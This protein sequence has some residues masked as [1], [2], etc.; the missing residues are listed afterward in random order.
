MKTCELATAVLLLMT[1]G[2]NLY[3]QPNRWPTIQSVREKKSIR[4]LAESDTPINMWIKGK[5]GARLY[6]LEC[7]TGNYD[8]ESEMNFSGDYQCALF[9]V[10]GDTLISGDLLA[11]NTKDELST[12]WWNRGRIRSD[13]LRG[14]CLTYLDYSTDRHF[15]LRGML[16]TLTVEDIQWSHDL[17]GSGNHRLSGFTLDISVVPDPAASSSRAEQISGPK[18]PSACYP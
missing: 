8:D 3:S 13:Q 18:P 17:S 6:K 7:H 10:K 9:A 15:R 12:D 16:V 11:E 4:N 14:E 2:C 1:S 5:A